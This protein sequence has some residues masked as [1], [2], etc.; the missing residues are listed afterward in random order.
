MRAYIYMCVDMYIYI[1]IYVYK[2]SY[3]YMYAYI[4]TY[5]RISWKLLGMPTYFKESSR[6]CTYEYEMPYP[7]RIWTEYSKGKEDEY[8]KGKEYVHATPR[9]GLV[10]FSY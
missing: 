7:Y 9:A 2:Y 4:Y 1:H 8:S 10:F 3:I 5:I 6:V